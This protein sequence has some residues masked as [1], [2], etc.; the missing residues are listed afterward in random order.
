MSVKKW[1][2]QQCIAMNREDTLILIKEWKRW[3]LR[4]EEAK[5]LADLMNVE[6]TEEPK[7]N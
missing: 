7:K 1:A 5:A 6:L 3:D 4:Y 2:Q